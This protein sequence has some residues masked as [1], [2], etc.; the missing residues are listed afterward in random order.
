MV[1]KRLLRRGIKMD[2]YD[3]HRQFFLFGDMVVHAAHVKLKLSSSV[4]HEMKR[5]PQLKDVCV[6]KG[7]I[8]LVVSGRDIALL[9]FDLLPD[10]R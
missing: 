1:M 2:L 8:K 10:V 3:R 4:R 6:V 7:N 5:V 9:L